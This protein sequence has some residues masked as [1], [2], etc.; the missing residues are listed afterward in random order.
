ME[1]CPS[2][3]RSSTGNAVTGLNPFGGSNPPLSVSNP[4]SPQATALRP[5]RRAAIST[6]PKERYGSKTSDGKQRLSA[7]F[8]NHRNCRL[9]LPAVVAP[10]N[11]IDGDFVGL[12]LGQLF[13]PRYAL[14]R[15]GAWPGAGKLAVADGF[16][17]FDFA[18]V[19]PSRRILHKSRFVKGK[20]PSP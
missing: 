5:L 2:G 13:R 15:V 7:R 19:V 1:R 18:P 12:F 10:E 17:I 8:R 14:F 6:P 20:T 9:G 16:L 11:G 3:R 4:R